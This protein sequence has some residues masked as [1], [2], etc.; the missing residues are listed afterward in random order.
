MSLLI[1][2]PLVGGCSKS[3]VATPLVA[4]AIPFA[5]VYR[6]LKSIPGNTP[7]DAGEKPI[8]Y[9]STI[10][11]TLEKE[12]WYVFELNDK[13]VKNQT[14]DVIVSDIIEP[15]LNRHCV[16]KR[17]YFGCNGY[18]IHGWFSEISY[19]LSFPEKS[20][21]CHQSLI[22]T[23]GDKVRRYKGNCDEQK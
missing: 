21:I 20:F 3:T 22:I 8:N 4:I 1:P 12:N 19:Q 9:K 11:N 16:G 18:L 7:K 23:K 13:K 2:L 17:D 10:T 5:S 15:T 6:G 14:P